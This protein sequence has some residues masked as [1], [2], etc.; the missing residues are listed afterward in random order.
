MKKGA[1][2]NSVKVPEFGQTLPRN[3]KKEAIELF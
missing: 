1:V 3:R 2:R